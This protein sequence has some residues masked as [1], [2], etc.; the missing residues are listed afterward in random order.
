MSCLFQ[1]PTVLG[2]GASMLEMMMFRESKDI[3]E[4]IFSFLLFQSEGSEME[5]VET[6]KVQIRRFCF[7]NSCVEKKWIMWY[8]SSSMWVL[9][10]L[11]PSLFFFVSFGEQT[12]KDNTRTEYYI[13]GESGTWFRSLDLVRRLGGRSLRRGS[14]PF[15]SPSWWNMQAWYDDDIACI[16]ARWEKVDLLVLLV[17][18][19]AEPSSTAALEFLE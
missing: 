16:V 3:H 10:L 2:A 5:D 17:R 11:S 7:K 13:Y 9:F 12:K 15:R 19:L 18:G 6:L 1:V 8:E 14:L 4:L